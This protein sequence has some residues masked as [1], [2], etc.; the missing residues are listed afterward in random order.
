MKILYLLKSSKTSSILKDLFGNRYQVTYVISSCAYR[1]NLSDYISNEIIDEDKKGFAGIPMSVK[2]GATELLRRNGT[3]PPSSNSASHSSLSANSGSSNGNSHG[4][5]PTPVNSQRRVTV[6]S[7]AIAVSSGAS[8]SGSNSN[9]SSPESN[10]RS[11]PSS[12]SA[13]S[14][15]VS[16]CSPKSEPSPRAESS[17]SKR[18]S[19]S[20]EDV[21]V[22]PPKRRRLNGYIVR[23]PPVVVR[24]LRILYSNQSF[25]RCVHS[26]QFYSG[27]N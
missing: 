3:T 20:P 1:K 25:L 6:M 12:R 26:T 24:S 8:S 4:N 16:E 17:S 21:S 13:P 18:A 15:P 27:V 14:P 22:P 23:S 5:A 2:N 19:D 9:G 11:E 7:A 10:S